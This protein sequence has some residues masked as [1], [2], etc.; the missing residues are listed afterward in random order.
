PH[1]PVGEGVPSPAAAPAVPAASGA[2]GA[3]RGGA[4]RCGAEGRESASDDAHDA[5]PSGGAGG[6]AE[7]EGVEGELLRGGAHLAGAGVV[8]GGRGDVVAQRAVALLA[9]DGAAE[10]ERLDGGADPGLE[11][12]RVRQVPAVQAEALLVGEIGRA[13]V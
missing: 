3:E 13:H 6:S 10:S 8:V 7:V 5:N 4:G 1:G 11:A 12:D 2:E 9:D